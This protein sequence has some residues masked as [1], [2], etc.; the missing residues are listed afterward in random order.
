MKTKWMPLIALIGAL[1]VP[2]MAQS[3]NL[4]N[5]ATRGVVRTGDEI[6]FSG[7]IVKGRD[8]ASLYMR[9]RGPSLADYDIDNYLADP[10]FRVLDAAGTEL[11]RSYYWWWE[12][13][14]PQIQQLSE[15]YDGS[16]G[17]P[18]YGEPAVIL[19][20]SEGA[21]MFLVEGENQGTGVAV[22][23]VFDLNVYNN[24]CLACA[25]ARL[26][27]LSTRGFVYT[28]NEIMI[29]GLIVE[30]DGAMK[31]FIR[32]RGPSLTDYGIAAPLEDPQLVVVTADG[33]TTLAS[34]DDWESGDDAYEVSQLQVDYNDD[35]FAAPD[36]KEPAV[37]LD[38]SKG[39]Y[40]ILVTG[41][42]NTTGVAVV[43]VFDLDVYRENME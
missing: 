1:L 34:N 8:T 43:E 27:N 20:A 30:G 31:T 28:G 2:A 6:M 14:W 35:G 25:D 38:L 41:V 29:G 32:V 42:N 10:W 12:S 5:L 19:S 17:L 4:A 39:A 26:A 16:L 24:H 11:K 36:S 13:D 7:V 23:E 37:I 33:Q 3:A 22:A 15:Q 40:S 18:E 21:Y 9:V